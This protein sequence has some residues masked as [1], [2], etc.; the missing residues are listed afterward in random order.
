VAPLQLYY[1]V[2]LFAP[3]NSLIRGK[4][5]EQLNNWITTKPTIES[6]WNPCLQTLDRRQNKVN[7]VAFSRDS[8]FLASGSNDRTIKIWDT[9]TDSLQ[10]TLESHDS[11][12]VSS[13]RLGITTLA[14]MIWR[15]KIP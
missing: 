12:F 7:S 3:Q 14:S 4:F 15:Q 2:L 10:Q 8:K 13:W 9:A 6:D 5:G 1:S 11:G